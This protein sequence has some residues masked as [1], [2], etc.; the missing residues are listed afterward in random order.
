[1]IFPTA[2][3]TNA[4]NG[5][6]QPVLVMSPPPQLFRCFPASVVA[7]ARRPENVAQCV[8][9]RS[10]PAYIAAN[11]G[12]LVKSDF[13]RVVRIQVGGQAVGGAV[14]FRLEGAKQPVPDDEHA[15]VIFV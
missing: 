1:M 9:Y 8:A 2:G 15:R 5:L 10:R 4:A 14:A 13:D 6:A 12:P 3:R 11:G 7:P